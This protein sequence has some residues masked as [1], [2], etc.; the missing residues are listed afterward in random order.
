MEVNHSFPV[1][2]PIGE[3]IDVVPTTDITSKGKWL[4][5]RCESHDRFPDRWDVILRSNDDRHFEPGRSARGWIYR[6]DDHH[7]RVLVSTDDFGRA[8]LHT[9]KDRHVGAAD[10][11]VMLALAGDT[12]TAS[13]VDMDKISWAKGLLSRCVKKDQWDWYTVYHLL[14]KPPMGQLSRGRKALKKIRNAAKEGNDWDVEYNISKLRDWSL[15]S[16]FAYFVRRVNTGDEFEAIGDEYLI[17]KLHA[18]DPDMF[19]RFIADCWQ[20]LGWETRVI[21]GS[22]DLGIDIIAEQHEI[23]ARKHVIQ[24]KRWNPSNLVGLADVQRYNTIKQQEDADEGYLI[25][26]SSFTREARD[27]G[28]DLQVKLIDGDGLAELIRQRSLYQV[29]NLY[30]GG[31]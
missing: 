12:V 28:Q 22:N 26:T 23:A 6:I 20:Q 7:R 9:L 2:S 5:Y 11:I 21:G 30:L 8:D 25:T 31:N 16:R 4:E 29:A 19:E 17:K 14:G 24:A 15:L 27:V 10:H 13:D 1:S 18:L 3:Y